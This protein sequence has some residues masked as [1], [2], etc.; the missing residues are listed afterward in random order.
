MWG[1]ESS[2]VG[3]SLLPGDRLREDAEDGDDQGQGCQ[4]VGGVS[5][6][7]MSVSPR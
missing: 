7:A 1:P 6:E 5:T 4:G 2:G 3:T